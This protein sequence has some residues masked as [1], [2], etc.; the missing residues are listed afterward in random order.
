MVVRGA[1]TDRIRK[2][3]SQVAG[4]DFRSVSEFTLEDEPVTASQP[5]T[6]LFTPAF[7]IRTLSLWLCYFMGLLV[8]Y[9]TTS[10]LPTMITDAGMPIGTAANVTAR[11]QLGGTIALSWSALRCNASVRRAPSRYHTCSARLR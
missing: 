3:L 2:E 1:G 9:L 4:E 8:I 11:F 5:V 6:L 10:W 7:I